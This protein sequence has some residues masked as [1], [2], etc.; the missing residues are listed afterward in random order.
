[1]KKI[2]NPCKVLVTN[3]TSQYYNAFAEIEYKDGRLSIHGVIA[4]RSNGDCLGSC[5]QCADEIRG[6][7]PT[8]NWT[9][10]MLQK[11]CDI[12]DK[13]HLNDMRPYCEHQKALGWDQKAE[14]KVTLYHYRQTREAQEKARAAESAA[15]KALKNG[16]TFTPTTEQVFFATLPNSLTTHKELDGENA[17]YYEPKKP[18]YNG[19]KGFTEEKALG[20]L[21]EHEHPD[22]ILGKACPICGY[23]Y[24]TE[25]KE[26]EVPQEV[27]EWLFNLPTTK[28]TPAW[29]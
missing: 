18:L 29:V 19:D 5:G 20:W 4:P 9:D 21:Y 12:W 25:W 15:I 16:E 13:Y 28:I 6:G 2:I 7:K 8:A 26:E 14:Q 3:R 27:I 1:M 24:G 10:E 11:F 23:K 17:K 22:G